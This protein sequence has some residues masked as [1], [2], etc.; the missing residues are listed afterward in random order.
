M[1]HFQMAG[2]GIGLEF[3]DLELELAQNWG[4]GNRNWP[5]MMATG[6]EIGLK[7]SKVDSYTARLI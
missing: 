7:L 2:L 5:G 6:I 1:L 4:H 3:G